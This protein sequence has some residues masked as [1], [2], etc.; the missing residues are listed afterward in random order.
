[1]EELGQQLPNT[2]SETV[3]KLLGDSLVLSFGYFIFGC[4]PLVVMLLCDLLELFPTLFVLGVSLTSLVILNVVKS[5]YGSRRWISA[6][7]EG[8]V[9]GVIC[10]FATIFIGFSLQ[11]YIWM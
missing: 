8:L 11:E 1:M 10:M 5:S 4:L 2:S 9:I 3:V 6:V 7:A